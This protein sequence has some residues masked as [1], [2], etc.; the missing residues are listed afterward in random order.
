MNPSTFP[1]LRPKNRR[2]RLASL[3]IL[4]GCVL[5]AG[6]LDD[7]E[8]DCTPMPFF[9]DHSPP[10]T[11]E[12]TI[13][14]GG[15]TLQEIRVYAGPHYEDGTLVWS[16]TSAQTLR[17]PLGEYSATATYV[18]GGKTTVAVDGDELDYTSAEYCEGTCYD[19]V[20]GT[21]DLRLE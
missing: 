14:T 15:G 7:S 13:Q 1:P 6:C 12:L 21:V 2:R 4:C 8:E 3:A 11:A 19:E 16:G 5:A 10:S 9:C 17:L 20:D 18:D